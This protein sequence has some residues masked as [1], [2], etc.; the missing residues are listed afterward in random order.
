MAH[1]N[2]TIDINGVEAADLYQDLISLEVEQDEALAGLFKLRL[3]MAWQAD[4]RWAYLDDD[5]LKVWQAVAIAAGFEGGVDDLMSGYI[6]HVRPEF[7]PDPAQCAL[8]IW[9]M[10]GSVLMDRQEK[11][12]AWPNK[13]DSDIAAE[14]FNLYGLTPAVEDTAVVHDEAVS[15]ILQ[16]E[17]DIKFLKRLAFRN[18]FECYVEGATGYFQAPPVDTPPQPVL[19]AHF[20]AETTLD[21]ISLAVNALA[22]AAVTLFQVDPLNKEVLETTADSSRQTILGAVKANDLL[23]PGMA[24]GQVYVD[25]NAT[26]GLPEMTA[27]GQELFHQAAWFV[28]AEGEINANQYGHVLK[29]RRP[30]TIKGIGETYSGVY[31]VAHVTHTFIPDGYSQFFRAKRNALMPTGTEDFSGAAGP[32]GGFA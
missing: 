14:I 16:R 29:P 6:T 15:T 8:E 3:A 30:V 27:L 17:T 19:A 9:G 31:Y 18:G 23:A 5:R 11:L 4:G 20:G 22:P 12:K 7:D 2:L 10:D 24:P 13:K 21:R 28:T 1:E 25:V 26:T 32:A